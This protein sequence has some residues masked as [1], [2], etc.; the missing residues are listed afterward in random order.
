MIDTD[1]SPAKSPFE[2]KKFDFKLVKHIS[3]TEVH[4]GTL[5]PN[6]P[7]DKT[8]SL[9][10][11]KAIAGIKENPKLEEGLEMDEDQ[12]E[13]NEYFQTRPRD[14]FTPPPRDRNAGFGLTGKL[15]R[16]IHTSKN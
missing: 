13:D 7:S 5:S 2:A 14:I 8:I 12:L 10:S 3:E 16:I 1:S 4:T 6:T 15:I 11:E 9:F